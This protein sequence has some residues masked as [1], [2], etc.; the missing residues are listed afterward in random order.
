M[1]LTRY[2]ASCLN[3]KNQT[4]VL[5]IFRVF[6]L[7]LENFQLTVEFFKI[8]QKKTTV[9]SNEC[10]YDIRVRAFMFAAN[11]SKW[12]THPHQPLSNFF[13]S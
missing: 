10:P 3:V 1:S 11:S 6:S 12:V 8:F 9:N 7:N 2:R 4:T 5:E 13:H